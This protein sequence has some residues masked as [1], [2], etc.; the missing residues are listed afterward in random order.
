MKSITKT[1]LKNV[2]NT[3]DLSGIR[4]RPFGYD[5]INYNF[6][7]NTTVDMFTEDKVDYF[8]I[9][10]KFVPTTT[11]ERNT[12]DRLIDSLA[13]A[14]LGVHQGKEIASVGMMLQN[15]ELTTTDDEINIFTLS[16][17]DFDITEDTTTIAGVKI[18]TI[19]VYFNML[20][21]NEER[22]SVLEMWFAPKGNLHTL[23][24]FL[25]MTLTSK[26]TKKLLPLIVSGAFGGVPS[27]V[28]YNSATTNFQFMPSN[29]NGWYSINE[30]G[31]FVFI[32]REGSIG[33]ELTKYKMEIHMGNPGYIIN[34]YNGRDSVDIFL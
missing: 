23:S 15:P 29:L 5:R 24:N 13:L 8:N 22:D 12:V 10:L 19:R 30:N 2:L 16:L 28:R 32:G 27:M 33:F 7:I 9:D 31:Y 26:D 18:T 14:E 25:E 17:D 3:L 1:R 4:F 34:M 11:D 21:E 20:E 6:D